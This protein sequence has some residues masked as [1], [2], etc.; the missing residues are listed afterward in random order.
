VRQSYARAMAQ[1]PRHLCKSLT[2]DQGKE[3]SEHKRFTVDTGMTVYFA[4][5]GSPWERGTN[6]N[7]NGLIR[8]YF[9]SESS[10][11]SGQGHRLPCRVSANHPNRPAVAQWPAEED[12]GM[13]SARRSIK[14]TVA[15]NSWK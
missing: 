4:H 9:P 8:Q 15:L 3:M 13:E 11:V 12:V 10:R 6:E 2:Y 14:R 7:T 1:L 5:P